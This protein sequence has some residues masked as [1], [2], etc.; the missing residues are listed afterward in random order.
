MVLCYVRSN[1]KNND[2]WKMAMMKRSRE[3]DWKNPYPLYISFLLSPFPPQNP[4][5]KGKIPP[6]F[7][8]RYARKQRSH[9]RGGG[10]H[11]PC[12][13][14]EQCSSRAALAGREDFLT[15][16]PLSL[17]SFPS[18]GKS[19]SAWAEDEGSSVGF[20]FSCSS[21]LKVRDGCCVTRGD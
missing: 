18:G 5:R 7:P 12:C 10:Q 1:F 8:S 9:K 21:R 16:P 17:S 19:I 20:A 6:T 14:S 2:G 4:S 13:I 11:H 15:P 3:Q